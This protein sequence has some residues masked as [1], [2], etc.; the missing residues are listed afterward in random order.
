MVDAT[1]HVL[2]TTFR[3]MISA[4]GILWK[5]ASDGGNH[6]DC[7]LPLFSVNTPGRWVE[8]L[9]KQKSFGTI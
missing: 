5:S 1:H 3:E 8:H 9:I 6:C 4:I 7:A 2:K